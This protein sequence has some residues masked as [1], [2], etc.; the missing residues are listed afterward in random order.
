VVQQCRVAPLTGLESLDVVGHLALQE[1]GRL[2]A[3]EQQHC[4]P[5]A[6]DDPGVFGQQLVFGSGDHPFDSRAAPRSAF[7]NWSVL[8]LNSE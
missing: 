5:G 8:S 2:A 7:S 4:P 6:L 1:L 3:L